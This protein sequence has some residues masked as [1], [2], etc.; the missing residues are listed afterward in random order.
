[1][2]PDTP[3]LW[4]FE[5]IIAEDFEYLPVPGGRQVPVCATAK[6]LRTGQVERRWL[7]KQSSQPPTFALGANDLY[8][9]YHAPAELVCR[10]VPPGRTCGLAD[11]PCA[12]GGCRPRPRPALARA[13]G[14]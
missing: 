9:T 1:M 10:Q 4:R 6:D 13:R 2:V 5:R 7:W 3:E 14:R 12:G 8:V 11:C